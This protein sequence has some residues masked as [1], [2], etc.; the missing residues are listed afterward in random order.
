MKSTKLLHTL[1]LLVITTLLWSCSDEQ[2]N[3]ITIGE[4]GKSV[5][6]FTLKVPGAMVSKH[7]SPLT[8]ALGVEDENAVREVG[9][10]LFD[11]SEDIG[12]IDYVD[13]E[14]VK[15]VEGTNNTFEVTLEVPQGT[16]NMVLI[17]NSKELLEGVVLG[18]GENAGVTRPDVLSEL[19]IANEGKWNATPRTANYKH[20]PMWTQLTEVLVDGDKVNVPEINLTRML[21]KI[22]VGVTAPNFSLESVHLYNY[23]NQGYVAPKMSNWSEVDNKATKPTVPEIVDKPSEPLVYE[24]ENKEGGKNEIK[25]EIYT[26]EAYAGAADRLSENTC[27]VVGGKYGG[28]TETTYYRIDFKNEDKVYMHLLRNHLYDVDISAI[29]G[30]GYSTPEAAFNQASTNIDAMV[31]EWNL[32]AID[33]KLVGEDEEYELRVSKNEFDFSWKE[34][35]YNELTVTTTYPGGWEL[36]E[37]EYILG[38][39]DWLTVSVD[40][41]HS[42]KVKFSLNANYKREDRTALVRIH[43]GRIDYVITVNQLS[44]AQ[45]ESNSYIVKPNGESILIPVLRANQA[46]V[47]ERLGIQ[48][49]E[50]D[51]FTAELVWTD[52][53][54]GVTTKTGRTSNIKSLEV[55]GKGPNGFLIVEPGGLEGNAVVAIKKGDK[56]LWSWHIWVTDYEPNLSEVFMTRNLG[57]IGDDRTKVGVKGLMYQWGRKDPFPSSSRLNVKNGVWPTLYNDLGNAIGIDKR[58]VSVDNNFA[59][60]VQNPKR[61]YYEEDW[62]GKDGNDHLWNSN[63]HKKTVYDP[64]PYGWRVP[65]DVDATRPAERGERF[66][67]AD[68]G[69]TIAGSGGF[70]PAAGRIEEDGKFKKVGERGYYWSA[71]HKD[72]EKANSILRFDKDKVESRDYER[73]DG[74]SVRCVR[75]KESD[76]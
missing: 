1:L 47:K 25:S 46:E 42:E 23:N 33:V 19:L 35:E 53:A 20:I 58:E 15:P 6:A 68:Y 44:G 63:D 60:S 29:N 14:A 50:D 38:D 72:K 59:N 70:Y 76:E 56:I 21:A 36:K 34:S 26:F 27:M 66:P 30:S 75:Y 45:P 8:Y 71:T 40:D 10:L 24:V 5:V 48:L 31:T 22:D 49:G 57:A 62:Y 28:D 7:N 51:V 74:L 16:Y 11:T 4:D 61:F 65:R 55:V 41:E 13:S 67:W 18:I 39:A 12:Y 64:C 9:L 54:G 17:V 32:F 43:V 2:V 73:A 52:N 37:P 69:I 3:D